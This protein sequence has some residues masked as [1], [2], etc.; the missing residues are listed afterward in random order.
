MAAF[1]VNWHSD[2]LIQTS[3]EGRIRGAALKLTANRLSIRAVIA[4]SFGSA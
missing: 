4:T 1:P 2:H 3:I